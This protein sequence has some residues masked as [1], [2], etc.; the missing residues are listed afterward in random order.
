MVDTK[1]VLLPY[2][3]SLSRLPLPLALLLTLPKNP[4]KRVQ[5]SSSRVANGEFSF[6]LYFGTD[7][8]LF[9]VVLAKFAAT[10]LARSVTIAF[11]DQMSASTT[12]RQNVVVPINAQGPGRGR[13]RNVLQMGLH[14]LLPQRG[15]VRRPKLQLIP[16]ALLLKRI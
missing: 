6:V 14:L 5:A 7:R 1:Q 3:N 13:A 16:M 8:V 12:Q 9:I 2:S 4:G 11:A 15:S 10:L